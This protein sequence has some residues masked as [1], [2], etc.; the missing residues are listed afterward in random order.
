M[1]MDMISMGVHGINVILTLGLLYVYVQNY[2]KMKSKYTIGLMIFAVFFLIQSAMGLFFE[3]TMVMYSSPA[4]NT[5]ALALEAIK[6]V[7][8][9]ILLWISWD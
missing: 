4:A 2:A 8:F 7:G 1:A 6:A 9:A 3:A 5:A